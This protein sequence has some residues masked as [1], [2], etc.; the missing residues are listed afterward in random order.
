M[1]D[2][3]A[4]A[5][6]FRQLRPIQNGSLDEHRSRF[7]IPW[8]TNVQNDRRITPVEQFGY[9]S[10]AEIP[11]PSCQK[12]LQNSA[13]CWTCR[14]P[15]IDCPPAVVIRDYTSSATPL[16]NKIAPIRPFSVRSPRRSFL[17]ITNVTIT[18][19][20]NLI[21]LRTQVRGVFHRILLP[22]FLLKIGFDLNREC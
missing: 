2:A 19:L 9:E 1:N 6:Y 4:A 20:E 15:I 13:S 3:I 5:K 8:R 11:R 12:H 10:L 18:Q 22:Y 17:I 16:F 7:H 14:S 21:L